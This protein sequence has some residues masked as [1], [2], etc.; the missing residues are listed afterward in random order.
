MPLRFSS[1]NFESLK[2]KLKSVI[3]VNIWEEININTYRA[4]LSNGSVINYFATTGSIQFQGKPDAQKELASK[5]SDIL[6]EKA[7][8]TSDI[9]APSVDL[10]LVETATA[11]TSS[12]TGKDEKVISNTTAL[13]ENK[14]ESGQSEAIVK[15]DVENKFLSGQFPNSEIVIALIGA[16]GVE[17]KHVVDFIKDR[18]KVQ[19]KYDVEEVRV[20]KQVIYNLPDFDKTKTLTNKY[21]H[22]SYYMEQ[23]NNARKKY[24]NNSVLAMGASEVIQSTRGDSN[25]K[26]YIINSLKHP[27]EIKYLREIYGQGFY[28]IGVFSDLNKRSE[29]LTVDLGLSNKQSEELMEKDRDSEYGHGLHT[30]DAFHLSDYFVYIEQDRARLKNGIHRFLD[31][32]FG[33]PTVTPTFD[34]YSMFMAFTAALRSADLSRQVGAVI[35]KGQE[36]ISTGANDTPK[37][38]GGL[39][40]PSFDNDVNKQ[41]IADFEGGRDYMRGYDSNVI[42][43]TAIINAVLEKLPD[44]IDKEAIKVVLEKSQIKD[45][46]EYGRVVHAEMEALMV[47]AR[48]N[49][50][51]KGATLYCTTFPCH[52][53]AKHII[54]SGIARVVYIEPYAK[55]K[56]LEF[57]SEAIMPSFK[58]NNNDDFIY[59]EPFI[60]LGPRKFFDMFSMNL[61]SGRSVTRKTKDGRLV[62]W[63]PGIATL[64]TPLIPLNYK[65]REQRAVDMFKELIMKK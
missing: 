18:L 22:I 11:I 55:S 51:S 31:I 40:W 21:D 2:D 44:N 56:A 41:K 33:S 42:E 3:D 46:T 15:S 35:A 29:Y 38:G 17:Y 12:D 30:S 10:A 59:F 4:K 9:A 36:I 1:G 63:D 43:K 49:S 34:E 45:L 23:G 64:K 5:V 26:A 57:H 37:A 58:S 48:T 6:N 61:G 60:G 47:C 20:S 14:S 19:F 39:Y 8:V 28:L 32:I 27:D 25:R 53:C 13:H 50:S 16:I 62:E 52:N 24:N 7:T 54:A 65:E